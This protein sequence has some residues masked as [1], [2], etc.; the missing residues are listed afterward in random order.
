MGAKAAITTRSWHGQRL[1]PLVISHSAEAAQTARR[2]LR[3]AG[4]GGVTHR[5]REKST[6]CYEQL[7][8]L[9]LRGCGQGQG[10]IS[11]HWR[12]TNFTAQ[13]DRGFYY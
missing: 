1:I 9:Q 2:S 5:D 13:N 3:A 11:A 6:Y 12:I 7:T 10:Q 8:K 4:E